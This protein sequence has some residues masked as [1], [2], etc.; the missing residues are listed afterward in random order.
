MGGWEMFRPTLSTGA[1]GMCSPRGQFH[2]GA[3][4]RKAQLTLPSATTATV[5]PASLT[6]LV[7]AT[8]AENTEEQFDLG[9]PL[10][11]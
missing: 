8:A 6:S 1:A 3:S 5:G 10:T 11:R 2:S 9:E 4:I 7:Y